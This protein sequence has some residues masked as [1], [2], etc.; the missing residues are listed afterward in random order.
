MNKIILAMC[1]LVTSLPAFLGLYL[2]AKGARRI[3]LAIGSTKWPITG[4]AVVGSETTRDVSTYGRKSSVTFDTKTTIRYSV[5]GKEYNT[6]VLHF[7][8]S[9]GSGDKSDAVLQRLRYPAGKEVPVYYDPTNPAVGVMKAGLSAE[10]FWLPGAGLAFLLPAVLCLFLLPR[11]IISSG[12]DDQAYANYVQTA[13]EQRRPDLPP[14]PQNSDRVMP[15]AGTAF[16]A[17]FCCLGLLAIAAGVDRLSHGAASRSWPTASGTVIQ[18][19]G[20]EP[21]DSTDAAYRARLVYKY[22]VAGKTHFN[23]L[24]RFA[25]VES[26][27]HY[28][29]GDQVKVSYSPADPDLAVIEPGNANASLIMPGIGVVLV[30]MSMAVFYWVVPALGK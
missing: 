24:R 30:L 20:D 29:T 6:N 15:I 7:G 9:L 16:G 18:T 25:E 4:G 3:Q 23:N 22:D 10:A 21:N 19:G 11:I 13:I 26:S 12:A 8:Q 5:N 17:V 2:F 1:M 28:K 14:P 27:A